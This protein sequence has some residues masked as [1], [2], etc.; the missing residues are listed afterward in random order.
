MQEHTPHCL[1][2]PKP[3]TELYQL[4]FEFYVQVLFVPCAALNGVLANK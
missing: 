4:E 3:S 1:Q 2:K